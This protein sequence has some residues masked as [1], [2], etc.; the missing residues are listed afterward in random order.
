MELRASAVLF[1][2]KE[3]PA[4]SAQKFECVIQTFRRCKNNYKYDEPLYPNKTFTDLSFYWKNSVF[5]VRNDMNLYGKINFTL[6]QTTKAHKG[7]KDIALL[8]L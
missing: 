7:S 5:S 2:G 1:P 4:P 3:F 6:E 8:F